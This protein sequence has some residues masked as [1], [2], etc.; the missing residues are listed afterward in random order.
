MS[1]PPNLFDRH[2]LTRH[3]ARTE[4]EAL[5]LHEA[6]IDEVEDR[7]QLVKR[8]FN[9]IGIVSPFAD[10]WRAGFPE[11]RIVPDSEIL[12][13]EP[14]SCDL[15]VHSMSLHWANDPVG[16]LIQCRRA[17]KPD[18]LFLGL[19]LGGRTLSELRAALSE[20]ESRLTGGLSPRINPMAEIRDTGAL[21][22]R[23]GLNL[24]VV[25]SF[26]TTASYRDIWHLMRDLRAMGE[27]NALSQ[28]RRGFSR[29]G[30]FDLA[31]DI[32]GEHFTDP[33]TNRLLATFE[34]L[35]LTGW[36]PDDSQPKP[37]R[38]GSA[39]ARLAEALGTKET[40]LRD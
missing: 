26:D 14:E 9:S 12:D 7:L 17:L 3:R 20:A 36:A 40:P 6:A 1:T 25:D 22:Q 30:I 11:A 2:A 27:T 23:A 35:C 33:N 13:L 10:L 18:G 34:T 4:R 24:P 31:Q 5:F 32:Y 15:I 8:S 39:T 21:L 28:R 29:R 19:M 37:L 16:Q 38:P